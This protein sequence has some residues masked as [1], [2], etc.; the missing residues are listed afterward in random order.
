MEDS[1]R[2]GCVSTKQESAFCHRECGELCLTRR[3]HSSPANPIRRFEEGGLV[4]EH[5]DLCP[6]SFPPLPSLYLSR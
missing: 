6:V 2:R 5:F 1:A 3:E 4:L